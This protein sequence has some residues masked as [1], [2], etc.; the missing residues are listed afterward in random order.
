MRGWDGGEAKEEWE[1]AQQ[2]LKPCL[3]QEKPPK[4]ATRVPLSHHK[5]KE[6]SLASNDNNFRSCLAQLVP[7]V[8]TIPL[9]V[10]SQG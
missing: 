5:A 8:G 7:S 6:A 9:M 1:V 10:T 2:I 3:G 4:I